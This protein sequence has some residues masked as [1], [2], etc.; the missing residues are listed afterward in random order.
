[1]SYRKT[2]TYLIVSALSLLALAGC[3]TQT[4]SKA[5][6]NSK[7]AAKQELNWTESSELATADLSKATDTLSFTVLQ[8][9]QEGLYRLDKSG[10]PK[11]ALATSTKVTNGGKTYTFNLRKNAKWTNGQPVTAKDFVYSWQRTV[12]P[13]TA[14]QDA[15]YLFQVKNAEAVNAGKKPLSAL[16]IKATGKYQLTV[17]LTKPVSY[18]KKLLAWPLFYPLNQKAVDHYGKLYGTRSDKTVYNGPFKLTKWNGTSK[19][20]TLA[21]NAHYWDRSAVHLTK[22]NEV[23]TTSTTTS[24]NLFNAKKTDETLLSGQQVKN[25]LNNENF[26]KR[27][28]TGTQRLDLNEKTVKAFKNVKVRQAFSAAIDRNQLVK[29]VLQ[30]GSVA[31]TGF[32]P[33]GM[34]NNPKTGEDFS[35]EAAVKSATSYDLKRA[36]KLLAQ[37]YQAT[38]TK[39]INATLSVAD[40]DAAKQ[41]AE[42]VQSALNKLPGVKITIKTVPYVQLITQQ[43]NGNYDLTFSG[44]QSVFADPINFLDVYEAD[45]SY[46]TASWKNA[47][48]DKLLDES[49][50][51]YGNQPAKRWAKLVAAEKVLLK[52]QGTIPLYQSA[53]SQLLRTNVKNIIYNPA[54][55]PYDFKT[56]YI[57]K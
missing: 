4:T 52:D 14:S 21:K 47:Q 48:F 37:G 6:G 3:G 28:P 40:T 51:Q 15:F 23:V 12:N 46:N 29:N 19:S 43:H 5:T 16:G 55:V 30:D 24:Y 36:K 45:S 54:G 33:A 26:V 31:S 44:W 41:A 35:K 57:A 22:I 11:N 34:G 17:N 10:T 39:A 8:N 38:G 32:V 20:W 9:T 13:K 27:L 2:T 7:Y 25:N 49:E 1:M 53:K 50:N 42:F 18:F 56:T